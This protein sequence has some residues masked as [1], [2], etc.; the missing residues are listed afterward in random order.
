VDC[1]HGPVNTTGS[2]EEVKDLKEKEDGLKGMQ[3]YVD[4]VTCIVCGA[5]L[6]ECPVDAIFGSEDE[7]PEAEKESIKKNYEFFGQECPPEYL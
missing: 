1:I 3:L 4:P 6:P 5:C 2:G 7:V